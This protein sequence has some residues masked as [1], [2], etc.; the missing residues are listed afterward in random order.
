MSCKDVYC[1]VLGQNSNKDTSVTEWETDWV[2]EEHKKK[3]YIGRVK[4]NQVKFS[5]KIDLAP[6]A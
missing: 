6:K 2:I 1:W 5:T 4:L 3:R